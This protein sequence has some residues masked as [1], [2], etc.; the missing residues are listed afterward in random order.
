MS[1]MEAR[2]AQ[3]IAPIQEGLVAMR[4]EIDRFSSESSPAVSEMTSHI[5]SFRG[6][7]LRGS[8][9]LLVGQATGNYSDEHPRVAAIV[10][11][12][13]LATLVHDDVLDGA[14]VRRR[15]ACVNERWD[16]QVAVLLGDF[17]YSRAFG[18]STQLSSRFCSQLLS[19]TTARLCIGEIEQ[20]QM[21]YDFEMSQENYER[22]AAAKTGAL[23]SAACEL[24]ARYPSGDEARGREMA[25]FG[26]EIGLAFQII[27]DCLDVMGEEE[28]VGKS[29]GNDITDGK[30]TLPILRT[31]SQASEA[32]RVK[33]REAYS[34]P[35]IEDR[36]GALREICD[37]TPGTEYAS[38]R[39]DAL[40]QS[41][42]NRLK[43]LPD[44]PARLALEALGDFVL[45]RGW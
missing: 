9:V 24:G 44:S 26:E 14:A 34:A 5:A 19:T 45:Q 40:V 7:Q 30:V 1:S 20:S 22:I 39:A 31:Y 27:D 29:V 11:L 23:Y 38:A 2:L 17:L 12:I 4:E 10:E 28:I 43:T 8:L 32:T 13:H 16:N 6:K 3:L 37:L 35:D 18:L 36:R 15:V 41:A 33:I 25:A 21:R 42:L